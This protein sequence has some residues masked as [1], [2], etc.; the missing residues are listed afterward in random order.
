M[1]PYIPYMNIVLYEALLGFNN[2]PYE[3][4]VVEAQVGFIEYYIHAHIE[5]YIHRHM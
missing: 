4:R 2:S 3:L 1:K 5:Y